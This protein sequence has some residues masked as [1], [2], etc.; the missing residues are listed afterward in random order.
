MKVKHLI[1]FLQS[2]PQNLDVAYCR[3]SEMCLLVKDDLF[4]MD[5]CEPRPDGWVPN[6]RPDK[7]TK[8]YLVFPGN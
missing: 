1:K 2:Q 4:I 5:G 3:Y 7:P 8:K 6:A